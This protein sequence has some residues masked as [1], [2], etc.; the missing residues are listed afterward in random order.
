[1]LYLNEL[2]VE[3]V[4]DYRSQQFEDLVHDVDAAIDTVGRDTVMRSLKVVKRG[5]IIVSTVGAVAEDQARR[6]G[7]MAVRMMMQKNANDLRELARLVDAG[8]I[9]SPRVGR[10]LPLVAAREAQDLYE[11]GRSQKVV[12]NVRPS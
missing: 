1:M 8:T 11:S 7:V 2:G 4:I 9:R 3:D 6:A 5:G 12:L 10:V